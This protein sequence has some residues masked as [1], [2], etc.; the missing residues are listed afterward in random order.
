MPANEPPTMMIVF[1]MEFLL[2]AFVRSF[3]ER[4]LA[5]VINTNPHRCQSHRVDDDFA[6]DP[7]AHF[8]PNLEVYDITSDNVVYP[9]PSVCWLYLRVIVIVYCP[10]KMIRRKC[11]QTDGL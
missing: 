5:C 3:R 7:L 9:K 1:D 4:C 2:V 10:Q 8:R 11:Q 6:F